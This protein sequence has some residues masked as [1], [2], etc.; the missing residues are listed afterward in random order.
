MTAIYWA[1][2]EVL[3]DITKKNLLTLPWNLIELQISEKK[4]QLTTKNEKI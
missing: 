2:S 4:G 3:L 1:L